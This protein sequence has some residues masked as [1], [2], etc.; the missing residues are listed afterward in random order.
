MKIEILK[1]EFKECAEV[2][3]NEPLSFYRRYAPDHWEHFLGD[4]DGWHRYPF[5]EFLEEA[6]QVWVKNA[7]TK[8][9]NK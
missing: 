7:K 6:F 5:T 4:L 2:T 3:T 8:A 9:A 1:V